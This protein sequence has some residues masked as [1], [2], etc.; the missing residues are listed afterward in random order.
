MIAG[1]LISGK[2]WKSFV[3]FGQAMPSCSDGTSGRGA[4]P[5]FESELDVVVR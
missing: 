1:I 2:R 4:G 5:V 3:R